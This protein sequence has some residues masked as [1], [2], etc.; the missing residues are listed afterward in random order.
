MSRQADCPVGFLPHGADEDGE[1]VFLVGVR[2]AV[3][4][5]GVTDAENNSGESF[6]QY[7]V[8]RSAGQISAHEVSEVSTC[9]MREFARFCVIIPAKDDS[10]PLII[11]VV[12]RSREISPTGKV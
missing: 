6:D 3:F 7:R 10:K 12:R 1:C 8:K 2:L 4:S 11:G 5:D 9:F